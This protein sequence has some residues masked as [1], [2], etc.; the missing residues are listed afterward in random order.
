[1][2]EVFKIEESFKDIFEEYYPKVLK[3]ISWMLKDEFKAEDIAQ[4]VFIK[5]FKNPPLNNENIE[6]WLSKVAINQALNYLRTICWSF[7]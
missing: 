7:L 4:E 6:G 2:R 5:F 3:Q 1:M